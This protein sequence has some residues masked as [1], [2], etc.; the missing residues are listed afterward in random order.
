M[1]A[2]TELCCVW[3][4]LWF[5]F[6][7][8]NCVCSPTERPDALYSEVYCKRQVVIPV[9][10]KKMSVITFPCDTEEGTFEIRRDHSE[11][12]GTKNKILL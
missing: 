12:D 3:N 4:A 5:S 1:A 7:L 10:S 11:N 2:F 6:L 9:A 8:S